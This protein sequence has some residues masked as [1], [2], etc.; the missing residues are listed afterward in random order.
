MIKSDGRIRLTSQRGESRMASHRY[1]ECDAR[2]W[3]R[4]I[5]L[6]RASCAVRAA[7]GVLPYLL[8]YPLP[9]RSHLTLQYW[10][11]KLS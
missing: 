10:P 1:Q 8:S 2:G 11:M 3:L 4:F 9:Y 7:C 6:S 5:A